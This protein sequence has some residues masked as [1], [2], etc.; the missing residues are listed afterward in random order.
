[1]A[2]WP[3]NK[4]ERKRGH[5]SAGI[6]LDGC[7]ADR[8]GIVPERVVGSGLRVTWDPN[9]P[10]AVMISDDQG[11]TVMAVHAHPDDQD[12]RNVV[13]EWSRVE[14]ASLSAPNDE[15]LSGHPLWNAGLKDVQ[16]L[17]LV[18]GSE[19]IRA[20]RRQNAVHPMHDPRRYDFLDHYIAPLKECVAEVV[21]SQLVIHRVEGTT[22]QA[23]VNALA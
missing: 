2:H 11:R 9:A 12:Q 15:A 20:L 23:A 4:H 1:M 5:A 18:Q 10:E 22:L 14:S 13:F 6:L 21:A 3:N 19:R 8:F 7:L 16:W 17:A